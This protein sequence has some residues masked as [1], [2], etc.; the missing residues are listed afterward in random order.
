MG[1]EWRTES[2]DTEAITSKEPRAAQ[3]SEH[4]NHI[5]PSHG[6]KGQGRYL[7]YQGV[8]GPFYSAMMGCQ[9]R[10]KHR[11]LLS[12]GGI[13]RKLGWGSL[14]SAEML[15]LFGCLL[16]GGVQL[17]LLLKCQTATQSSRGDFR[18][19][20]GILRTLPQDRLYH[21]QVLVQNGNVRPPIQN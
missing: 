17:A 14:V 9:V 2:R 15:A 16:P 8:A 11:S 10:V 13:S 5:M 19:L 21:L 3:I 6:D 12:W 4:G 18:Q 7:G 20:V 1:A